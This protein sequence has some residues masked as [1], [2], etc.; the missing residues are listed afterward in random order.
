LAGARLKVLFVLGTRPETIKLAPVFK[1]LREHSEEFETRLLVTAQHRTLLDDA[2]QTFTMFPDY[3]LD[4]MR[5]GQSLF[6]STA[7]I[8]AALEAVLIKEDPDLIL[9]QGDTTTTLCGALGGFYRRIPVG[10]V[11]AGLRTGD[12]AEPFPEEMNRAL[13]ARLAT[14]HFASTE[15]A[16]KNLLQEGVK[17]HR[18][19]VTGNTGIDALIET[20]AG[21]LSG[22]LR[23]EGLPE[24]DSRKKLIL[25]TAHRRESF[26]EGLERICQGLVAL[27]ARSDVEIVFP[28]HPNPNVRDVVNRRLGGYKTIKL[29]GPLAYVPFVAL[30]MRAHVLLTDSGGIQEEAPSLGKPVLV[31][32]D[33]TERAEA[34]AGG[35]AR[36]VG[37]DPSRIVAETVSLLEN[38]MEYSSRSRIENPFGDGHAST[39]ILGIIRSLFAT[40]STLSL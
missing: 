4:I 13:V 14:L 35:T 2:L 1:R 20:R 6:E 23:A 39:R 28:V 12:L 30:M 10:H 22:R 21:L 38:A 27:A 8:V 29:I 37:A 9:V 18:I 15:A 5:P 7:R 19:F 3:D 11:E 16:S 25:V 17:A 24:L 34:V 36:L 31:M 32:R 33:K 40:H 26:G